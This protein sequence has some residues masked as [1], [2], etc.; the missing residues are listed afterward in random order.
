M[1][2]CGLLLSRREI[3]FTL[4]GRNL[5]PAFTQVPHPLEAAR[6]LYPTLGLHS[7]D[8]TVVVNLGG[9]AF[10]FYVQAMIEY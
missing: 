6:E 9:S 4:N 1:V 5:G 10:R 3:F 7:P 2:G 8:E